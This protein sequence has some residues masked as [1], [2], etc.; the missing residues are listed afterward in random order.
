MCQ[1]VSGP[2]YGRLA[3]DL[4]LPCVPLRKWPTPIATWIAAVTKLE[5]QSPLTILKYPDPRLRAVNAKI[6]VF[7]E[8][9]L[10]LA[11]EMIEVMYT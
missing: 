4:D 1:Q 8:S 2:S 5:W 3:V 6:G 10:R 11:K 9:L 7:D